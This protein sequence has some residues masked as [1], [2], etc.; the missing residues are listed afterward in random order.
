M[1]Y[2]IK[3]SKGYVAVQGNAYW[4]QDAPRGW[5]EFARPE[6]ARNVAETHHSAIG[7][8]TSDGYEIEEL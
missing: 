7:T 2:A 5:A 6:D 3:T 8:A 4:F 1:T